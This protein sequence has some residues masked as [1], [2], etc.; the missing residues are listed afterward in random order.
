VLQP[1]VPA[2]GAARV[3]ITS[4]QQLVAYLGASVPVEVFTEEDALAFLAERTGQADPA[5]RRSWRPSWGVC[6]SRW[7]RPRRARFTV[8]RG[9]HLDVQHLD[10]VALSKIIPRISRAYDSKRI[11]RTSQRFV[12]SARPSRALRGGDRLCQFRL[13]IK[14]VSLN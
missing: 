2:A 14:D 7:P 9:S 10:P 11:A 5:G 8:H 6:R 3:I 4:N 1:F 13:T 12:S